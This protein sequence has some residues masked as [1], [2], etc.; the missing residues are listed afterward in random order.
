[1]VSDRSGAVAQTIG[2]RDK[3]GK[4][5]LRNIL[6]GGY[7][8]ILTLILLEVG[9]RLWGYSER[10]I[11]DPIYMPFE[12]SKDISYIY[13]PNLANAR[14]F[15]LT[16]IN[17]DS[18]GLRAKISG[19]HYGLKLPR[20]YRIAIAGDSV[21]FGVGVPRTEDTF[22]PVLE[23]TLNRKQQPVKV[24]VFN[25]GVEAYSVKQMTATLQYRML[26]I[27]PDLVVMAIIPADF[28]L[29]RTPT[30][31]P[32]GYLIDTRLSGFLPPDSGIRRVLRSV[33][34]TYPLRDIGYSWF[35]TSRDVME[36]PANGELPESYMYIQQ[37]KETAEKH[38]V[39]HLIVLLPSE[40]AGW[41][42]LL[43]HLR[44]DQINFVD[45][46]PIRTEFSQE[47]FRA[48]RF[49]GH[50]SAAVHHRI[51]EALAD[52]ILRNQLRTA[53]PVAK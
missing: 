44:R 3:S 43:N 10:Y 32:A 27:Q 26:A 48:N 18:L 36:S 35:H 49:D 4:R 53:V 34:L 38:K 13:K 9:V 33:H 30:V 8:L 6:V 7:L 11:S 28:N 50:P 31:N 22:S 23:D 15:G 25:Y 51:G 21:T 16:I 14:A 40:R 12:Q 46:S 42:D 37:F 52:S 47:R 39:P 24:Q 19:T 20:Q 5:V 29:A 1:M 41:G 2:D 17:T 45:L